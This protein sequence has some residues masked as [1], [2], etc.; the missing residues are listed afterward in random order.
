MSSQSSF[1]QGK[2]MVLKRKIYVSHWSLS[3]FQVRIPG[4]YLMSW[5]PPYPHGDT[6][7]GSH[8]THLWS[9]IP[10]SP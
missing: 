5:F 4:C 9:A 2:G 6:S 3:P 1:F 10:I 8:G 7:L